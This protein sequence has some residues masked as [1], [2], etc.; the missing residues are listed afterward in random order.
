MI[1]YFAELLGTPGGAPIVVF[2]AMGIAIVSGLA[3]GFVLTKVKPEW[4]EKS[5]NLYK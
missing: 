1:N 4:A 3:V 2:A 5:L